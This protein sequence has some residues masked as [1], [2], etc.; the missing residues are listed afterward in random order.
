VGCLEENTVLAF[1]EARLPPE[2]LGRI[3]SHVRDCPSCHQLLVAAL[4]V[5]G[6]AH[7]AATQAM[8]P[9]PAVRPIYR[10]PLAPGT[11]V[12]RFTVLR[13]VGRGGMG[14]VYAAYDPS[15]DRRVALKVMHAEGAAQDDHAQE[16][17]QREAQS[18]AKLSHPNVVVVYEVGAFGGQVF[19]AM[20]FVE[21][22]T[23]A[24]WLTERPRSWREILPVFLQA[25]R[26]LSAAHRAGLVHRDFKPQ[27]VMVASDGTVRVMDFGLA[28]SVS[29]A[30]VAQGARSDIQGRTPEVRATLVDYGLTRTGEQLGTP[31]YMAPEQFTGGRI[32]ARSDQF[33]FC[34]ALYWALF[35]VHPFGGRSLSELT[36]AADRGDVA[37]PASGTGVPAWLQR[38]VVRGLIVKPE[39]RWPSMDDLVAALGRD[40]ASRQRRWSYAAAGLIACGVIGLMG[41][42]EVRRGRA[43]CLGGPARLEGVWEL[44]SGVAKAGSRRETV[45]AAI[46]KSGVS[47]A[48]KT[49]ERVS[50][51]LDRH[52]TK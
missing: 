17:L 38:V 10:D 11:S 4:N 29:E 35:G 46:M 28:R 49:W 39:L 1:A 26:G 5:P 43:I 23:L 25:A 50:E 13:L 40:P 30:P 47:E 14:E 36:R 31:L 22:S 19:I 8:G 7:T 3:E 20:E 6:L 45:R 33:S 41:A 32:D 15:L 37:A 44:E 16:R 2:A 48:Q 27:N 24:A 52:A 34:V 12:G 21:G 42:R 51:L 18:I 9:T